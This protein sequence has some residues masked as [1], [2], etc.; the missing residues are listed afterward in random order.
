MT[1]EVAGL[2]ESK[3]SATQAGPC[4]HTDVPIALTVA[5]HVDPVIRRFADF[6]ALTALRASKSS[7]GPAQVALEV[8]EP[9]T[10]SLTTGAAD[11]TGRPYVVLSCAVSLDGCL[12]GTGEDRLGLFGG[13][14]L[15]PGGAEGLA[16][17]ASRA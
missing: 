13:A 8:R 15:G 3:F 11:M 2:T 4:S 16:L 10:R 12:D 5:L 17:A 14:G 7:P 9:E 1:S 6:A